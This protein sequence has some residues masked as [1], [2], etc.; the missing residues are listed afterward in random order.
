MD[1][2]DLLQRMASVLQFRSP[3]GLWHAR[4]LGSSRFCSGET[5]LEAMRAALGM[6]A[7]APRRRVILDAPQRPRDL[8]SD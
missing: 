2:A 1:E 8:F 6:G 4:A 3:D 7:Q 5:A